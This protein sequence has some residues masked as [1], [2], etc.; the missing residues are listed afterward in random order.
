MK[1]KF[2]ER[3]F[4]TLELIILTAVL[5]GLAVIFRGFIEG[6]VRELIQKLDALKSEVFSF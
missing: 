6:F 3:G 5:I 2:F 4:G 1:E